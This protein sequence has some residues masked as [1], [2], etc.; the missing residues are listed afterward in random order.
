MSHLFSPFCTMCAKDGRRTDLGPNEGFRSKGW[1]Y[2]KACYIRRFPKAAEKAGLTSGPAHT[3]EM[4]TEPECEPAQL[5]LFVI[6][7]GGCGC[8]G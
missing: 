4:V 6:T 7:S 2:C 3:Q 5:P 8:Q 1:A